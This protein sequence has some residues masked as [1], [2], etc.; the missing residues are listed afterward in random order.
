[1]SETDAALEA[2]WARVEEAWD[3]EDAHR[4]FKALAASLGRLDF[5]G[6]RYRGVR[7]GDPERADVAQRE[8]DRL[9]ALAMSQL[10]VTRSAEP[11]SGRRIVNLLAVAV[12]LGLLLSALW[13]FLT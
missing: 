3:D 6:T 7:D 5:A 8:I 4:K 12:V 2:A 10:E 11:K 1:M 9:V 13:V